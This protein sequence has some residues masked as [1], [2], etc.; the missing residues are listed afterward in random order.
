MVLFP[1]QDVYCHL[2]LP[3]TSFNLISK[4]KYWYF[5]QCIFNSDIVSGHVITKVSVAF[6]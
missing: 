6:R 2:L 5:W 1:T 3:H 4:E